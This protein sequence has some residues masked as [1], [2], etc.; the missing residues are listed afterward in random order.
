LPFAL[1]TREFS[2]EL[3]IEV[4]GRSPLVP[5]VTSPSAEM[6]VSLVLKL[7]V[8]PDRSTVSR[9]T[10]PVEQESTEKLPK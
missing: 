3:I 9:F 10:M 4:K 5:T 6:A 2:I 8:L 7:I 1:L